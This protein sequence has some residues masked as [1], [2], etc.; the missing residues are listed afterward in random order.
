MKINSTPM[1]TFSTLTRYIRKTQRYENRKL[2]VTPIYR[3]CRSKLK[4]LN[5]VIRNHFVKINFQNPKK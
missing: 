5:L 4:H 3:G 1:M 2:N